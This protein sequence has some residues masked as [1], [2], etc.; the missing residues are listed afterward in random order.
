MNM[1]FIVKPIVLTLDVSFC[2]TL[3]L[4]EI[5]FTAMKRQLHSLRR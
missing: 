2:S 5:F 4:F 3:N 1:H